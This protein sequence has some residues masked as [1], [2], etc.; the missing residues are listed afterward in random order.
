VVACELDREVRQVEDD[1]V[2]VQNCNWLHEANLVVSVLEGDGIEA[3]VPDAYTL[4]ARP[5][6]ATALGGVRVLVRASDLERAREVLAATIP[7]LP[8]PVDGDDRD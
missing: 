8:R 4:G 3:F 2:Q 7:D 1:W 6:L 5:E